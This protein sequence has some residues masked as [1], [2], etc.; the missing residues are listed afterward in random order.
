M[1]KTQLLLFVAALLFVA[2]RPAFGQDGCIDSPE[3]P[4]AILALA[5]SAGALLASARARVKGRR[6]R[7]K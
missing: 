1:K 2:V 5:G 4:T 6:G 3:N 7:S